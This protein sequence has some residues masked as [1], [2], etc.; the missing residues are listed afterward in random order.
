MR[1]IDSGSRD[2]AHAVGSW[3]LTELTDSVV[4]LRVQSGFFGLEGLRPFAGLLARLAAGDLPTRFVIGSNDGETLASHVTRLAELLGLPRS[5]ARLGIA[6]Y[7]RAFYHPK[8][9]HFRR[10]DGSQAAYV[11]SANLT[12]AGIASQ[13]IEAGILLDT[14]EGDPTDV[15]D[16]VARGVDEWFIAA[17]PGLEVITD[18]TVVDRLVAEGV[19][20]V[21]PPPRSPERGGSTESNGETRRP[22]LQILV[23]L[24]TLP[25]SAAPGR[26]VAPP[27]ARAADAGAAATTAAPPT[28][29]IPEVPPG[30]PQEPVTRS[31][32]PAPALL[33]GYPPYVLFAPGAVGP[34]VGADALSGAGLPGGSTGLILR[35]TK[36]SAR[37]WQ[38]GSGT[39]NIS[40]PVPTVGTIQFGIFEGKYLR[41][42]AEFGF[43]IRYVSSSLTIRAESDETNAMVYGFAKGESGHGDVRM[44]IPLPSA[45]ELGRLLKVQGG[46]LPAD[47]DVAVLEWPTAAV[48]SFRLTLPERGSPLCQ[49]FEAIL[50]AATA[51]GQVVGQG[52]CWLPLGLSPA[53]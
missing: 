43:E 51:A 16:A 40:L 52:A 12:L 44:V 7:T 20:A 18:V 32:P 50:N 13:N 31:S 34:T 46:I 4:E 22:P 49:Q 5:G 24:P 10:A 37:H 27:G 9:Y 39:A 30:S 11:G 36:D 23:A 29:E 21:A 3:L 17:R 26:S 38:G 6:S 33:A 1:Y 48:P 15:L 2:P 53:W 19:L 47:G 35:L 14:H 45:R 8:T 41:P 25:P 28:A 42:R